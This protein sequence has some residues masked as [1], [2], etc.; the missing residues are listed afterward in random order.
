MAR[1][2]NVS[3]RIEPSVKLRAEAVLDRLGMPMSNAI[4][5]FLRQVAM[6]GG[7]PFEVKL[8]LAYEAL[9]QDEFDAAMEKGLA[10]V[11]AGRLIPAE[12]VGKRL[13]RGRDA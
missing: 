9:T 7:L 1:T 5:L 4:E 11:K 13:H 2:S 8:P 12:E 6:Q 3:A 10:D